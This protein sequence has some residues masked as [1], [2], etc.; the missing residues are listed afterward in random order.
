A[1]T[2]MIMPTSG[3]NKESIFPESQWSYARRAEWCND[4]YGIDPRPNWITTV[5]GGH[6]IYRVLKRYG[7]NIIFFNGL[8]DPWSGGGVL[9]NISESIVAIVAEK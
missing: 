5:F 9:K 3:N 1:C 7:S 6:D 4:S 2:E 8:R